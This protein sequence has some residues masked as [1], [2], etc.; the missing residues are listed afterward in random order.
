MRVCVGAGCWEVGDKDNM[1]P[2][3]GVGKGLDFDS[4]CGLYETVEKRII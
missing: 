4:W 1:C 2:L 3:C